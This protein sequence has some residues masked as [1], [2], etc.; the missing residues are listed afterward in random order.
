MSDRLRPSHDEHAPMGVFVA[1]CLVGI[2]IVYTNFLGFLA[3]VWTG[4]LLQ[5]NGPQLGQACSAAASRAAQSA[6]HAMDG[7]RGA[8]VEASSD[9]PEPEPLGP[10]T[11]RG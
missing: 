1:G 7:L 5:L 11:K 9:E 6:L 10:I 3:G 4:V 2:V 8:P